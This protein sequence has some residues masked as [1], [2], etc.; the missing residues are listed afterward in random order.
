MSNLSE[1]NLDITYRSDADSIA[2]EFY[3]PCL[4]RSRLYRRA[5]GYFTS[6]ALAFAAKGVA[7]LLNNS[8]KIQ[9]VASPNLSEEDIQAIAQGYETRDEIIRRSAART[10]QEVEDLLIKDRLNALAW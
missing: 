5:V 6:H 7:H 2:T 10:F 8:G 4:M 1:L 9:L 3:I